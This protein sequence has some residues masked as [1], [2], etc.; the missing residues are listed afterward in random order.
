MKM[1]VFQ[2]NLMIIG[3]VVVLIGEIHAYDVDR[4][5]F[6]NG[7]QLNQLEIYQLEQLHGE[8]IP[9]GNYWLDYN[10]GYWGYVG[11]PAQG[12]LGRPDIDLNSAVSEGKNTDRRWFEDKVSD[13]CAQNGGC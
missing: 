7:K 3:M 11:G 5:V 4:N 12:I 13:F 10:S 9:D 2:T 1:K 6:V 8:F